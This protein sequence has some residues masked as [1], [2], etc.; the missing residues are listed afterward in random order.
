MLGLGQIWK[1]T[2]KGC[3]LKGIRK[4]LGINKTRNVTFLQFFWN[5]RTF[6]YEGHTFPGSVCKRKGEPIEIHGSGC[7]AVPNAFWFLHSLLPSCTSGPSPLDP[8]FPSGSQPCILAY[9]Y[10]TQVR[11]SFS[12]LRVS[13]L[14]LMQGWD[15]QKDSVDLLS[16]RDAKRPGSWAS[17]NSVLNDQPLAS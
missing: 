2:S 5:I 6:N 17:F 7:L 14:A 12:C 3:F 15:K 9:L 11:W 1:E 8:A 16:S 13:T 10:L 4:K